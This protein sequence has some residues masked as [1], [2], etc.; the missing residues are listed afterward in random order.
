MVAS[1]QVVQE[2]LSGVPSIVR[3]MQVKLVCA[4]S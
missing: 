4:L 3:R 1:L 2:Q